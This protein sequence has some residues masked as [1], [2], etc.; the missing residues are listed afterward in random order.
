MVLT[1]GKWWNVK[2]RNLLMLIC[3]A[4][5]TG[6]CAKTNCGWVEPI[7]VSKDDYFTRGTAEQILVHNE[8]WESH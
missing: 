1:I 5:L 4:V 2:Y 8:T 6:G 3:V 7:M